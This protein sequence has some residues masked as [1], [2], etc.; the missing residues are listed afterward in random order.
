MKMEKAFVE[1][2]C[3]KVVVCS[4][5]WLDDIACILNSYLIVFL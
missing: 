4:Y 3:V 1:G 5:W 2:V